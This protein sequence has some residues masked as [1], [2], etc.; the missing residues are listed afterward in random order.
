MD[1]FKRSSS[2]VN[3]S[4]AA[5]CFP[6]V[7]LSF[8]GSWKSWLPA[9]VTTLRESIVDERQWNPRGDLKRFLSEIG[10]MDEQ[11]IEVIQLQQTMLLW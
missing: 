3:L 9:F 8:I 5:R 10:K 1:S 6:H 4:S 2:W 11:E 7:F